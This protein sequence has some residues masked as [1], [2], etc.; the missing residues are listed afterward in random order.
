MTKTELAQARIAA[1][2]TVVVTRR[3][4]STTAAV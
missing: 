3:T 2:G 1:A 4:P